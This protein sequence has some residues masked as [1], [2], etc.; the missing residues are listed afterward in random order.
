MVCLAL[1]VQNSSCDLTGCR[2]PFLNLRRNMINYFL[3]NNDYC[4]QTASPEVSLPL[5]ASEEVELS[6]QRTGYLELRGIRCLMQDGEV[7][8]QGNVTTYYMKQVAQSLVRR[9]AGVISVRNEIAVYRE[10]I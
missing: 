10:G 9:I 6:L 7:T 2:P 5:T 8:L 3:P 1:G 4:I